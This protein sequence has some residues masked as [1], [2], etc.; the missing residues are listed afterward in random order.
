MKVGDLVSPK[1]TKWLFGIVVR[2]PIE[3]M[4]DGLW[5]IQWSNEKRSLEQKENLEVINGSR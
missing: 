4:P 1:H 2:Q 3:H 5:M